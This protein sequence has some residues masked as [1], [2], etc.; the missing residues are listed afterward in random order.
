MTT[1][2]MEKKELAMRLDHI[3][4][5]M[6]ELRLHLLKFPSYDE[7]ESVLLTETEPELVARVG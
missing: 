2:E 3:D 7:L 5:C 4:R 1:L 6:D